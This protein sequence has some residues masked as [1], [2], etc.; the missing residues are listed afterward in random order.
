M[1]TVEVTNLE[2][3]RRAFREAPAVSKRYFQK[4]IEGSSAVL[5]SKTLAENPVP[6]RTGNLLQS[7]GFT[8]GNLWAKW[9]PSAN[10][11]RYVNDGTRFIKPR[12]FM[13][14]ISERSKDGINRLFGD[15]LEGI[16]NQIA[17]K[18]K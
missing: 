3:I 13:E 9:F 6:Y 14:A 2:A 15:A 12:R 18:A 5:A 10:Y 11:A 8:S 16:V 1:I 17:Q 7:F 4:A